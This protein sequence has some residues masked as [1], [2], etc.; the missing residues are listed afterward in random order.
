MLRR[1]ILLSA[2]RGGIC[3]ASEMAQEQSK[4][5]WSVCS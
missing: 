4:K 1:L 2:R 5:Q 3:H